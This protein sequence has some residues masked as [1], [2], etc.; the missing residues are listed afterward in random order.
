MGPNNDNA[1]LF[2]E[3]DGVW[4]S[5]ARG[6]K[7]SSATMSSTNSTKAV[8]SAAEDNGEDLFAPAIKTILF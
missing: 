1:N 4:E 2:A 8:G 6:S 7:P 3:W 5:G